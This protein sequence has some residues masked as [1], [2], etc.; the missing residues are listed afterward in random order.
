MSENS[1]IWET[2]NFQTRNTHQHTLSRYDRVTLRSLQPSQA[3]AHR[4]HGKCMRRSPRRPRQ[5][6]AKRRDVDFSQFFFFIINQS[7]KFGKA[8]R[9]INVKTGIQ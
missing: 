2:P 9:I 1:N 6:R 4:L 3:S 7:I 8:E 5:S